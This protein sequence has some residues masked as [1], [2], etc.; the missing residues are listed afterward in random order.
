MK[1]TSNFDEQYLGID[2]SRQDLR[3]QPIAMLALRATSIIRSILALLKK[4][5]CSARAKIL[6]VATKRS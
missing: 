5:F 2:L 6:M 4:L 3:C 1:R